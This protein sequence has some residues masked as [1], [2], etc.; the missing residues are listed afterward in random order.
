MTPTPF[1]RDIINVLFK[2]NNFIQL[3]KYILIKDKIEKAYGK[4][5]DICHTKGES[6]SHMSLSKA[7]YPRF[8]QESYDS[9]IQI[10][11]EVVNI[12]ITC[13]V[14]V[15]PIILFPVPLELKFGING[16]VSGFLEEYEVEILWKLLKPESLQHLRQYYESDPEIISIREEIENLPDISDEE[17]RQQLD[18]FDEKIKQLNIKNIQQKNIDDTSS[19]DI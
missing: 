15:N 18:E 4:L 3:D 13:F 9:F 10:A 14:V 2:K 17:L 7:N 8:I 5:N 11:K 6:H 16:P 12:V 1:K 19:S